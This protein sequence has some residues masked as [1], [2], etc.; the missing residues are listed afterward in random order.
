MQ[1]DERDLVFRA[2]GTDKADAMQTLIDETQDVGQK[3]G[4]SFEYVLHR[5]VAPGVN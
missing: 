5:P 4:S 3:V 2:Y 1:W